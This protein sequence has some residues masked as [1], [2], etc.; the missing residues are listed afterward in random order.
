MDIPRRR[1]QLNTT[2]ERLHQIQLGSEFSYKPVANNKH[3][4][5]DTDPDFK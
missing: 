4:D 5:Y 2:V 1:L 3:L